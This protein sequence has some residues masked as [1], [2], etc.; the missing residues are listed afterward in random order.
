MIEGPLNYQKFKCCRSLRPTLWVLLEKASVCGYES[1]LSYLW[2]ICDFSSQSELPLSF[3]S[4][5]FYRNIVPKW[6]D[7][8]KHHILCTCIVQVDKEWG[9]F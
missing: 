9:A 8:Q 3:L 7:L 2:P 4:F 6:P 1:L 5:F